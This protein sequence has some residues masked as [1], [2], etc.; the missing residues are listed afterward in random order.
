MTQPLTLHPDRLLP[1]T[2]SRRAIAR[3][4]L[5]GIEALPIYSPHGHVPVEWF[6]ADFRFGNAADLLLTPDHYLLRMLASQGHRYEDLGVSGAG[7]AGIAAPREA[8]RTLAANYHLYLGTPSRTWLDHALSSVLSVEQRLSAETADA[9]FDQV[10]ET[11]ATPEFA[12]RA[13]LGRFGVR[14]L[15]TTDSAVDDL[16]RHHRLAKELAGQCRV[17]PTFRPD[18]VTNPEHPDFARDIARLGEQTG[19][20]LSDWASYLEA[21]RQRRAAFIAAG[22]TATDHGFDTPHTLTLPMADCQTLLDAALSGRATKDQAA[23]FRAQMLTEM[24]RMSADDGLVMQIHAGSWR[25]YAPDIQSRFG[26]DMGYDIPRP[27]NWAAGL[28]PMLDELGFHPN[29]R[30]ILYTLDESGYGREL[31][32]L[33][34]AFPTLRLGAPWWFFDSPAGM[35]RQFDQVVETAGFHN[36]AGFVDDTRAL[37]SIPARHDVYRR[38]VAAFLSQQVGEHQMGMQDAHAVARALAV[39]LVQDSYRLNNTNEG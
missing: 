22:A 17:I 18:S 26:Q 38:S 27:L 21:L 4:L 37:L 39:E 29:L 11:V 13:L 9:I 32:P 5:D 2:P 6:D 7:S 19:Q 25:N 30:I 14:V 1:D 35:A 8:F 12:P 20:N 28:K 10:T 33:A 24:A 23:Q 36:L 16:S 31:A 34:G 3:E 15:S